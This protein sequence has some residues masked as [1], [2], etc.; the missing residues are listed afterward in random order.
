MVKDWMYFKTGS[1]WIY[2]EENSGA[3][4]TLTVWEDWEGTAQEVNDA[5]YTYTVSSYD[6]YFYRYTYN[7]SFTIYCLIVRNCQCEKIDRSKSRPGD[8]VGSDKL[9]LY[10][11]ILTNYTGS[12]LSGTTTVTQILSDYPIVP[13]EL[14]Q[15]A[16]FHT[17]NNASEDFQ[18]T[19]FYVSKHVGIIRKELI[20]DGEVWNLIEY[21]VI[22]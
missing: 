4:D 13:K 19:F 22:Q 7:S 18:E 12:G 8:F 9:F 20:S 1:Y 16:V 14:N 3:L 17:E 10:P 2:Q 21:S 11:P 5:F 15:V 6:G